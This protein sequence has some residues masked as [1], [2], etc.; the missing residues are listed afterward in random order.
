MVMIK[1][2]TMELD[3]ATLVDRMRTRFRSQGM[4]APLGVAEFILRELDPWLDAQ[5]EALREMLM[6]NW[7]SEFPGTQFSEAALTVNLSEYKRKIRKKAIA[8]FRK[9]EVV[10]KA[11]YTF[12][13]VIFRKEQLQFIATWAAS[14]VLF[15]MWLFLFFHP[16]DIG[17]YSGSIGGISNVIAIIIVSLRFKK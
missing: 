16:S 15:P 1:Q 11:F 9:S 5:E 7:E 14:F 8:E 3:Y 4:L 17:L 2:Q 6:S 10:Q 12:K 13:R